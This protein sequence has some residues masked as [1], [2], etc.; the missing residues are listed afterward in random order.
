M[1]VY[2]YPKAEFYIYTGDVEVTPLEII[3]KANKIFNLKID[4]K[5]VHFIY[6]Q[7]RRLIEPST[8]P[9]FTLLGQALGSIVLAFEALSQ[10]NPSLLWLNNILINI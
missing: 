1:N 7:K 10:L 9:Y 4:K 8:Y 2:R 3:Q 6:L 5:S